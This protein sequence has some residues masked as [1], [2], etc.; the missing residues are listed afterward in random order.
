MA[1]DET[2]KNIIPDGLDFDDMRYRM[3]DK[4]ALAGMNYKVY[5]GNGGEVSGENAGLCY[6][7]GEE[8][9]NVLS[10]WFSY[11]TSIDLKYPGTVD[12][13]ISKINVGTNLTETSRGISIGY[14]SDADFSSSITIG[15]NAYSKA[16]G[17]VQIGSGANN[18]PN[19]FKFMDKTIVSYDDSTNSYIINADTA[20]KSKTST[21]SMS[22]C[23][24]NGTNCVYAS[25]SGAYKYILPS[26]SF[27][28]IGNSSKKFKDVYTENVECTYLNAERIIQVPINNVDIGYI[29]SVPGIYSILYEHNLQLKTATFYYGGPKTIS[30]TIPSQS[31]PITCYIEGSILGLQL[32]SDGYVYFVKT[33]SD[34]VT[35]KS[36]RVLSTD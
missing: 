30:D 2:N 5:T 31:S 23:D 16:S 21:Q 10:N 24:D 32:K 28:Y 25:T 18:S 3:E 8:I 35:I 20:T 11:H 15:H 4:N 9:G 1:I 14:N 36:C 7:K 26:D 17:A 12:A 22:I 19:S 27:V 6:T 29:M 33:A 34:T 13:N